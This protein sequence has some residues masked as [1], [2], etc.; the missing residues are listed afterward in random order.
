MNKLKKIFSG[1][2]LDHFIYAWAIISLGV[3]FVT[4]DLH[5]TLLIIGFIL[6]K[7]LT[8]LFQILLKVTEFDI[9]VGNVTIKNINYNDQGASDERD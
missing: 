7:I 9:K 1:L 3:G 4:K 2:T 8:A 6:F 5:L